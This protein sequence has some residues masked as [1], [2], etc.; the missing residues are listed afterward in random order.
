MEISNQTIEKLAHL[1]Q[2]QFSEEEKVAIKVDLEKMVGFIEQL[3]KIDTT[4]VDPLIHIT[5]AVN[6]LRSD[7]IKGNI[8]I[9]KALMNA[10]SNDG[11]FFTVPKVIKK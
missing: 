4:N 2:L 1:A 10:P 7:E 5:D 9:E 11:Q 6:V 3:Q 8:T